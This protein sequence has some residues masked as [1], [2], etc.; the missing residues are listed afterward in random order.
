MFAGARAV[1]LRRR[2]WGRCSVASIAS[3]LGLLRNRSDGSPPVARRTH[4]VAT[5]GPRGA[6]PEHLHDLLKAGADVIRFNMS[7]SSP[8]DVIPRIAALRSAIERIAAEDDG[9]EVPPSS[10]SRSRLGAPRAAVAIDLKGPEIRTG[11]LVE[12]LELAQGDTVVFSTAS[13]PPGGSPVHIHVD[14]PQLGETLRRAGEKQGCIYID[15]G[16]IQ[17]DVEVIEGESVRCVVAAGG[18]LGSRKGVN[19]PGC[20]VDLPAVSAKDRE[21]LQ[22][23][24][25]SGCDLVFASFVRTGEQVREIK[26]VLAQHGGESV[27]VIAKIENQE[28]LDNLDEIL[29]ASDGV[30]V[31][32][33]DLG[34]EIPPEEVVRA[35]KCLIGKAMVSAKPVICATQMLESMVDRPR[36]TRA[37]ISDVGNA[38]IDGADCVMLSAETAK[39]KYFRESV[40]TMGRVCTLAESIVDHRALSEQLR[41]HILQHNVH[42][43]WT[44][45]WAEAT[46]SSSFSY[47]SPLIVCLALTAR[48]ARLIA[49]MRPRARILMPCPTL[50]LCAVAGLHSGLEPLHCPELGFDA[51]RSKNGGLIERHV[52]T[53]A[54]EYGRLRGYCSA[55]DVVVA[56]HNEYDRNGDASSVLRFIRVPDRCEP[57]DT[58]PQDFDPSFITP[59]PAR[60]FPE[61]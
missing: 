51:R 49:S 29:E 8:P 38:V 17:C 56:S 19:L 18:T 15:D 6:D 44:R 45:A 32:R 23:A 24:A 28:G 47:Q 55:G 2:V 53:R 46:V 22:F 33:G 61:A 3:N 42:T 16:L 58:S 48:T 59:A 5:V 7:H 52:V 4:I 43:A 57:D 37:E 50:A 20:A 31:A 35:Q 9:V 14:Y 27:G 12:P 41:K 34:I 25:E 60:P 40:E 26:A 39:G 11:E 13:R 10:L 54:I 1:A 30:M 36:A 21:D